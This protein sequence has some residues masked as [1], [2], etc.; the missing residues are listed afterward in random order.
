MTYFNETG[1]YRHK[2]SLDVD[3]YVIQSKHTQ[4]GVQLALYYINKISHNF[5]SKDAETVFVKEIDYQNWVYLGNQ[6]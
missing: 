1:L 3:F 5:Y 6:V 2:N 4:N